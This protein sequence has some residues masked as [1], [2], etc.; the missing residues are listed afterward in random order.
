VHVRR[1]DHWGTDVTNE[2]YLAF[3]KR[4]PA[5]TVAYTATD[6]AVTQARFLD[7]VVVGPRVRP[8]A[9]PI[10][11]H[12]DG[13]GLQMNSGP[14]GRGRTI[15][16]TSLVD[17]AVDLLTCAEADGPFMGS[18]TS[19]FSD[20]IGRLRRLHSRVH[21]D[22]NHRFADVPGQPNLRSFAHKAGEVR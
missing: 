10:R 1:T 20:T 12:A 18:P 16:H 4:Q 21:A 7:D 5:R 19:S 17:A 9:K 3:L 15:R 2:E 14:F 22:D 13:D 6:N 11:R 8:A